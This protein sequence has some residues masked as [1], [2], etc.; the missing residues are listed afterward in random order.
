MFIYLAVEAYQKKREGSKG[1]P[2]EKGRIKR[3]TKR[4]GKD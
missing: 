1:I 2:K 4:K 3:H